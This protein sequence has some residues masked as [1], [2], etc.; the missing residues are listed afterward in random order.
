MVG[1][2]PKSAASASKRARGWLWATEGSG[3]GTKAGRGE[4]SANGRWVRVQVKCVVVALLRGH[5]RVRGRHRWC[6]SVIGGEE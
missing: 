1:R 3:E 6:R 5:S 2:T 4:R